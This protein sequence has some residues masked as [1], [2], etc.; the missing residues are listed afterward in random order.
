MNM[1][2]AFSR[3]LKIACEYG[4]NTVLYVKGDC[5]F[6]ECDTEQLKW[7]SQYGAYNVYQSLGNPNS[8][9]K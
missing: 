5:S 8:V 6:G 2:V 3:C 1:N 4:F 9:L 7:T